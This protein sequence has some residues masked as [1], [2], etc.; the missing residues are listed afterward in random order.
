M[1]QAQGLE[2]FVEAGGG[3]GGRPLQHLDQVVPAQGPGRRGVAAG[4]FQHRVD[5]LHRG[6]EKGLGLPVA[7]Q[8][9]PGGLGRRAPGEQALAQ[10]HAPVGADVAD[11]PEFVER[12]PGLEL[13]HLLRTV[14]GRNPF[15]RPGER[16]ALVRL[17]HHG[18]G[19]AHA[20]GQ[21]GRPAGP[22]ETLA[23]AFGVDVHRVRAAV[24][25]VLAGPDA[26][27]HLRQSRREFRQG[28]LPLLEDGA[29]RTLA[30]T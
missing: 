10:D 21:P 20:P 27:F 17:D 2:R 16:D 7:G 30:S 22:V 24:A 1:A 13:V 12:A 3:M 14:Q 19:L 6:V 26:A 5:G 11:R 23:L 15:D 25:V 4:Q 18:L 28:R 29:H 8:P 9:R